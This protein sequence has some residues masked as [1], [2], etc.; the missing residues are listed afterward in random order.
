MTYSEM[1][2]LAR[3]IVQE[4]ARNPEWMAAYIEAQSKQEKSEDKLISAKEAAS[5]LGISV[6]L[7][8]R[9]KDDENG[10]PQF[11][12]RKGESQS[13]PLKFNAATLMKEYDAYLA[14]RRINK[15]NLYS[16]A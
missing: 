2:T 15:K 7:L 13:S 16:A 11:S 9:I 14:K 8:Y 10:N 3:L 4:Q 1:Q 12:Y 5:K 6:W